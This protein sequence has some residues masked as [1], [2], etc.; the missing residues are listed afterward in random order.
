MALKI[1]N[2]SI[3]TKLSNCSMPTKFERVVH[4]VGTMYNNNMD[5]RGEKKCSSHKQLVSSD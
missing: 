1:Y 5:I 3:K 2:K 4:A